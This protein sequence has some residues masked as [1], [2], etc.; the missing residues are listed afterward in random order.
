MM[1]G[2]G[3]GRCVWLSKRT[4]KLRRRGPVEYNECGHVAVLTCG[5]VE[6]RLRPHA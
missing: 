1:C 6:D 5:V 2:V 3:G 4:G